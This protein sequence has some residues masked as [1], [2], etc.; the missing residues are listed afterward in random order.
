[1]SLCTRYSRLDRKVAG[2]TPGR[3]T[4]K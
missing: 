2:L 1:M 4:V 3:C